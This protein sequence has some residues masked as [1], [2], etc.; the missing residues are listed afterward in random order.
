M[1]SPERE[2]SENAEER[3]EGNIPAR[4]STSDEEQRNEKKDEDAA[5][6]EASR[7]SFPT[8]DPP[9]W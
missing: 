1:E 5:V 4:H 8:S 7:D 6:D 9:A 3:P 2:R